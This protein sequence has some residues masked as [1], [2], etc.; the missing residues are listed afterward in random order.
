MKRITRGL[1]VLAA[2]MSLVRPALADEGSA[3]DHVLGN[4][5]AP[6]VIIEYASTTC[7]HCARFHQDVLPAL[8]AK[9]LD[10]GRAKLIYR[11]FPTEPRALS[12]AASMIAH[13]AG[14]LRYF[15][16]IELLMDQQGRW[17]GVPDKRAELRLIGAQAGMSGAEV[18]SCW[19]RSD[20]LAAID[21]RAKDGFDRFHVDSTPSFVIGDRV[22]VGVQSLATIEAALDAAA[23]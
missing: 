12:F 7:S 22:M 16:V 18:E 6:L 3:I 17:M 15:R 8:K 1:V 14:P 9:W 13:C 2:L 23:R 4:A 20:L 21:A 5:D 10:T 19:G 11:D